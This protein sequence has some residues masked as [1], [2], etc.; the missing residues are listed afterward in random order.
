MNWNDLFAQ[1]LPPLVMTFATVLL[2]GIILRITRN[3]THAAL[4][5]LL[6]R[7]IP[8]VIAYSQYASD[9]A[10]AMF[11]TVAFLYLAMM[12]IE[13]K[14]N[15]Y[16][17]F[18]AL[19]C[20]FSTHINYLMWLLWGALAL[21]TVITYIRFPKITEAEVTNLILS[22]EG[23]SKE[24]ELE[25]QSVKHDYD[26][27]FTYNP[28]ELTLFKFLFSKA[29]IFTI[30]FTLAIAS[31]WYLRNYILTGNPVYAFFPNIF[32]GININIDVLKSAEK[33]WMSN[34]DGLWRVG[35]T[36][37]EKL[38]GSWVYF[39]SERK[40][41]WKVAP[42]F[43]GFCIPGAVLFVIVFI[44]KLL[45]GDF[46]AGVNKRVFIFDDVS[47]FYILSGSL[48]FMF[49]FYEYAIASM[50]LY[51]II[52]MLIPACLFA[53]YMIHYI[54]RFP[55][56]WISK[57]III[58]VGIIP[59][60]AMGLMGFKYKGDANIGGKS[61]HQLELVAFRNPCMDKE[62]FLELVY[63]DD[64][65]M[66]KYI[67]SNLKKT[68]ILTHENRHLL[69]DP[70]IKFIHLDDWEIQKTYNM[71]TIEE[72]LTL[73]RKLGIS[74]YLYV[75]NENNHAINKKVGLIY[76]EKIGD[77]NV[78]SSDWVNKEKMT[79]IYKAGENRLYRFNF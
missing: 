27:E 42:V 7:S 59:G 47:K 26:L 32:G 66:A 34:G 43:I 56:N 33:E 22:S 8:Y 67:N 5:A 69:Y 44:Y 62:L 74:Y 23:T 9:Y 48:L 53:G 52:P 58:F 17:F 1:I 18:A 41:A 78:L 76:F 13:T 35:S 61:Y 16:F 37:F 24:K 71:Q 70:T 60:V 4:V 64:I 45:I 39:V 15:D 29:C 14:K 77:E 65:K 40:L 30:L 68:S 2:Y 79:L 20:A 19:V 55:W 75:P 73:F 31:T 21:M 3:K 49:L 72:K 11:F 6:F 46:L 51:Q 57:L 25:K 10:F 12:F 50:Y 36:T 28:K 38:R 63:G 54:D